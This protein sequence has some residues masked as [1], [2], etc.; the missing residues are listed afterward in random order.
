MTVKRHISSSPSRVGEDAV[1]DAARACVLDHG[2][3]R[4]TLT[5]VAR[6]AEVSRMTL[7]RRFPDVRSLLSALMTREFGRQLA[8]AEAS[9]ADSP[10]AR[11]RLVA[12]AVTGVDGITD[13][14]IMRAIL[15]HDGE[16]LVPYVFERLGGT[17]LLTEQFL[18]AQIVAGHEDGSVRAGDPVVQTRAF[19]LVVQSFVLSHRPA[20]AGVDAGSLAR[21][22]THMLDAYLRPER[23]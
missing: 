16:L 15:E 5:D 10:T 22:L 18:H 12:G 14:P 7:Y 17:Q 19:L 21:E 11:D 2:V 1:L 3:R 6:R 4:T 23:R 9:V 20:T 8:L 13:D